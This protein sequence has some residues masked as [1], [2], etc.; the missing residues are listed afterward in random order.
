M[1]DAPHDVAEAFKNEYLQ[2]IAH[3][4]RLIHQEIS[5]EE[6]VSRLEGNST[7]GIHDGSKEFQAQNSRELENIS[8][9]GKTPSKDPI[10]VSHS[11]KLSS[12]K[13][14]TGVNM[15]KGLSFAVRG[16]FE[17]NDQRIILQEAREQNTN[18]ILER[19]YMQNERK[20][21]DIMANDQTIM[22]RKREQIKNIVATL[23]KA[24]MF[25]MVATRIEAMDLLSLPQVI[26]IFVP[27]DS[28]F[29]I[30]MNASNAYI[31]DHLLL[32]HLV[33]P[34][35]TFGDLCGLKKR[36]KLT[37]YLMGCKITIT[38][39]DLFNY[40]LDDVRI[41][42]PDLYND[43]SVVVHGINGV[44]NYTRFCNI[45]DTN[46]QSSSPKLSGSSTSSNPVGNLP[47]NNPLL[48][49]TNGSSL[50]STAGSPG[51][52]SGV[53]FTHTRPPLAIRL[54]GFAG[55]LFVSFSSYSSVAGLLNS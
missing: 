33:V 19:N 42:S 15:I 28:A 35:Y 18:I 32:Y 11:S 26:T 14:E 17:T 52:I 53:A 13:E 36:N 55:T 9:Y 8:G 38:E 49:S 30:F 22:K 5:R 2:N 37:T 6:N 50:P 51:S 41:I 54:M 47:T 48:P 1:K 27:T 31:P 44:L 24:G 45:D 23:R 25:A 29:D 3:V 40:T 46:I 7:E 10:P 21:T 39:N 34:R 16:L 43:D 4:Q 20:Q 12:A